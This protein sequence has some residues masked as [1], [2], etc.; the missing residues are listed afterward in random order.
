MSYPEPLPARLGRV[1]A[2]Y[3]PPLAARLTSLA[4]ELTIDQAQ[5]LLSFVVD[6]DDEVGGRAEEP[7][8]AAISV[9]GA[10][11]CRGERL[12]S[13]RSSGGSTHGNP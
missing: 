5:R 3:S 12:R 9:V 13:Y 1:A 11:R 8:P 4:L 10:R 7:I 2:G 6:L